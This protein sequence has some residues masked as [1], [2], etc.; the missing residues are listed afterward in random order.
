MEPEN[1]VTCYRIVISSTDP[2]VYTTVE[3]TYRGTLPVESMMIDM[4]KRAAAA[5]IPG[6]D[7]HM[8]WSY[9]HPWET[10]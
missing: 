1:G 9:D 7:L 10:E 3:R 4:L 8:Q 2:G 6:I 5:N